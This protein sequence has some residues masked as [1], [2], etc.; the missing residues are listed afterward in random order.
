[1]CNNQS[2]SLTNRLNKDSQTE[3]NLARLRVTIAENTTKFEEV[4]RDI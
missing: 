3:V 4:W 2:K 1:M